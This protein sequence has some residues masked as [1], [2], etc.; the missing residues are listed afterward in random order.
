M[1]DARGAL[2]YLNPAGRALLGLES[3]EEA[4]G[5]SLLECHAPGV[6]E[7]L[8]N[9]AMPAA[10]RD[11]SWSG[12]SVL[13]ARDGREIRTTLVLIAH[14]CDDGKLAGFSVQE[15]DMSEWVKAEEALRAS[16]SEL[17]RLAHS[18]WRPG[19]RAAAHCRRPDGLAPPTRPARSG[20]A[21]SPARRA[22]H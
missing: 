13:L 8:R 12:E 9:T 1:A 14:H 15:R 21:G 7:H 18:T 17:R 16:Q 2:N 10:A 19:D 3:Q 5:M 6:R 22:K 11:G 4:H 20:G